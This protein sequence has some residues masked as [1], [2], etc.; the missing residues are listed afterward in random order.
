MVTL[1]PVELTNVT[2]D[3]GPRRLD[4]CVPGHTPVAEL[5]P[6]LLRHGSVAGGEGAGWEL[7][8]LDGRRLAAE[9]G[10]DEQG[11]PDG[12]VLHLVPSTVDWP[13]WECDD[14]TETVA[15]QAATAS[16]AWS[17]E[18]TR[19]AALAA[20]PACLAAALV[21]C[22]RAAPDRPAAPLAVAVLLGLAGTAAA[23]LSGRAPARGD[24]AAARVLVGC[25]APYA[26]T[27]AALLVHGGTG[28]LLLGSA[29]V[30]LYAALGWAGVPGLGG[31]CAALAVAGLG[32]LLGAALA[33]VLE[34]AGAAA[35]VSCAA[36]LGT[37]AMPVLA[38][39]LARVPVPVPGSATPG[40][41]A[42]HRAVTRADGLFTGLLAGAATVVV[43]AAGVLAA[44]VGAGSPGT[45][46][47]AYLAVC[48][49]VLWL[50]ARAMVAVRHRLPLLVAGLA[51][52]ALA[53]RA[54]LPADGRPSGVAVTALVAA[55]LALAVPGS[56]RDGRAVSPYLG[57]ALDLADTAATVALVPLACAAIGLYERVAALVT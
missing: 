42:V 23:R 47:A 37:S 39:R 35:T 49:T 46:V 8:L 19:A 25:G 11:V 10:L 34:P 16:R 21:L 57:R 5:L 30:L 41:E 45:R 13:D 56:R 24:P 50:R 15:A 12:S 33:A 28:R 3:L 32:G 22:V 1:S 27:G 6:E 17:P 7:R 43:A 51:G 52:Y 20:T 36:V 40:R 44:G 54:L 2:V 18:H 29:A 48:A 9:R 55:A 26:F 4:V 31:L 38:V 14:V 53:G